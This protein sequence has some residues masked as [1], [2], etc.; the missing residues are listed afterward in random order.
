MCIHVCCTSG[1]EQNSNL[2]HLGLSRHVIV[3]DAV[4][5]RR[6][7][8]GT[9]SDVLAQQF[10]LRVSMKCLEAEAS[11]VNNLDILIHIDTKQTGTVQYLFC[12]IDTIHIG[13]AFLFGLSFDTH[14][15]FMFM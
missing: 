11:V 1:A 10:A 13:R 15:L 7:M 2:A 12:S 6:Q 9:G 8:Y 14:R 3:T 4:T 5:G